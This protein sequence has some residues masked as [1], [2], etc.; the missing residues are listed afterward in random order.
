M[1]RDERVPDPGTPSFGS[2][3]HL[4]WADDG[5]FLSSSAAP[6][7]PSQTLQGGSGLQIN[8]RP[9]SRNPLPEQVSYDFGLASGPNPTSGAL[10]G[11]PWTDA[12]NCPEPTKTPKSGVFSTVFVRL[13]SAQVS[14]TPWNLSW[15]K[16][17]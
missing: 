17:S 3:G 4:G 14:A 12:P 9:R 6:R 10:G 11:T 7:D 5:L 1:S 2:N 15:M 13:L 16:W 8:A